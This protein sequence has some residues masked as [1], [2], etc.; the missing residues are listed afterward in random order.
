MSKESNVK[1]KPFIRKK[2]IG[3]I[4]ILGCYN[5]RGALVTTLVALVTILD[6]GGTETPLG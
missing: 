5:I 2:K 1:L 3:S 6:V 4:E